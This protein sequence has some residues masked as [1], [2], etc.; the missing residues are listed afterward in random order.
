MNREIRAFSCQPEPIHKLERSFKR[1]G[2]SR[3]EETGYNYSRKGFCNL[4]RKKKK[5]PLIIEKSLKTWNWVQRRMWNPCQNFFSRK[6]SSFK[7]YFIDIYSLS[8]TRYL[9]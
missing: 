1:R 2:V 7:K 4:K 6:C 5:R 9:F 8:G 3:E